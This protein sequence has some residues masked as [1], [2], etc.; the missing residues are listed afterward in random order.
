MCLAEYQQERSR[1]ALLDVNLAEKIQLF[2]FETV[3]R[4]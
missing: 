1:I 3:L 2:D 4:K